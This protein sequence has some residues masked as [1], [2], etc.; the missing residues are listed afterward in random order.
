MREILRQEAVLVVPGLVGFYA[1]GS[2][3]V[4]AYSNETGS[5]AWL[6]DAAV[7][8]L[9]TIIGINAAWQSS[10]SDYVAQQC[11]LACK[12]QIHTI[13]HIFYLQY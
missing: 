3:I 12:K 11:P 4:S 10:F 1:F 8:L 13:F 9:G 2:S 5:S 7:E 6:E